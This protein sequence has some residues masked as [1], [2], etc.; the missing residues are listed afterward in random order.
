MSL[1]RGGKEVVHS[2]IAGEGELPGMPGCFTYRE[3]G[4]NTFMP[5]PSIDERM[6]GPIGLNSIGGVIAHLPA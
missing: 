6:P 4:E 5:D 1:W 2:E 3:G